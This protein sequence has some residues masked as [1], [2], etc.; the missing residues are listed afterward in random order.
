MAQIVRLIRQPREKVLA[1]IAFSFCSPWAE[2]SFWIYFM[3]SRFN[4][5]KIKRR[6]L[7]LSNTFVVVAFD[8]SL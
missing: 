4:R 7:I 5:F 2:K 6:L 1:L 8:V 3:P